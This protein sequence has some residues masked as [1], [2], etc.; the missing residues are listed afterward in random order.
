MVT[1][2]S[3]KE[4][5]GGGAPKLATGIWKR[6]VGVT[7]TCH[8]NLGARWSD[9]RASA[10]LNTDQA[11][12]STLLVVAWDCPFY[13]S[14][15]MDRY[16]QTIKRSELSFDEFLEIHNHQ[17]LPRSDSFLEGENFM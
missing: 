14:C 4:R 5:C 8:A 10:K 3:S 1:Q 11:G 12:S 17:V 2:L 9:F 16:D 13:I 6:G 15:Y 7:A